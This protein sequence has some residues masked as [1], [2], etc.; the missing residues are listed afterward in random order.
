[1]ELELDNTDLSEFVTG[2][3]LDEPLQTPKLVD[4]VCKEI[5]LGTRDHPQ[6]IK[7]YDG[8]QGQELQDWTKFFHKHKSAFAWTYAD[9]HGIPTEIAEH[10]IV[11]EEDARPIR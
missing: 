8:I 9:L 7:V 2:F 11:L 3:E 4:P 5:N 6:P 10:H 1:M